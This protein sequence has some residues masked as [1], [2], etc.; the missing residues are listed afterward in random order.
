MDLTQALSLIPLIH[1]AGL[2]ELNL[3]LFD[4]YNFRTVS[5]YWEVKRAIWDDL[6]LSLKRTGADAHSLRHNLGDVEFKSS[7]GSPASFMWDKQNDAVRREQTLGSDAF[8]FGKFVNERMTV[9]LVAKAP[10]TLAHIRT[11]MEHKQ[12]SALR[13][14]N[15]NVAAGRRGGHDAITLTFRELLTG[16]V[17]WS[18]W[19]NGTWHHEATSRECNSFMT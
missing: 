13:R 12:V 4:N 18:L 2:R 5:M 19:S 17:R 7:G 8:V 9:I 10:E 1:E 14:W 11:L 15:E 6:T 3:K 16:D